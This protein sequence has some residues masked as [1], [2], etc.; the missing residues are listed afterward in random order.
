MNPRQDRSVRPTALLLVLLLVGGTGWAADAPASQP[1]RDQAAIEKAFSQAF[2]GITYPPGA[3]VVDKEENLL[4]ETVRALDVDLGVLS[5]PNGL[6]HILTKDQMK[7]L[8]P[9]ARQARAVCEERDKELFA[10]WQAQIQ[11]MENYKLK[12]VGVEVKLRGTYGNPYPRGEAKA[13]HEKMLAIDRGVTEKVLTD[14][15][16]KA[17]AGLPTGGA[18]VASPGYV[19]NYWWGTD[20]GPIGPVGYQLAA[21]GMVE[22]IEKQLGMN[23]DES[24]QREKESLAIAADL[25]QQHRDIVNLHRRKVPAANFVG[26]LNL[27]ESQLQT[28]LTLSDEVA[29]VQAEHSK[30]NKQALAK[31]VALMTEVRNLAMD[32]KEVPIELKA[33]AVEVSK[34]ICRGYRPNAETGKPQ[35]MIDCGTE[36]WPPECGY[37]LMCSIHHQYT[38]DMTRI[39]NRIR[40]EILM[41]QQAILIYTATSCYFPPTYTNNPVRVGEVDE[42]VVYPEQTE[43]AR[44]RGLS[45]EQYR[46]ARDGFV[47]KVVAKRQADTGGKWAEARRTAEL[48][49]VGAVVDKARAMSDGD[50]E[51][52]KY[53]FVDDL[54]CK[55]MPRGGDRDYPVTLL[56]T[57]LPAYYTK[58]IYH[59]YH[60]WSVSQQEMPLLFLGDPAHNAVLE[61]LVARLRNGKP[62]KPADLDKLK[63]AAET[64]PSA[65]K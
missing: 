12:L 3:M 45:D 58:P 36:R 9:Y 29:K 32:G 16:R 53:N 57:E 63:V 17:L 38:D 47:A 64:S 40:D 19:Q 23:T 56:K 60:G 14:E 31:L 59:Y 15:Q 20:H 41:P 27:T 2:F 52:K 24:A 65:P 7:Q 21:P 48:E 33:Q 43:M 37:P 11:E 46:A 25:L 55:P 8:L 1:A 5:R 6:P 35:E 4:R 49:R 22:F 62:A 54:F 28:L 13:F 50:F 51:L 18:W 42:E 39:A 26:G 61:Q 44:L 34:Q 10:F 30:L